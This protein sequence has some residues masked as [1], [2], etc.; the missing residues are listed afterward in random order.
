MDM[1]NIRKILA[2]TI[3]VAAIAVSHAAV[4]DGEVVTRVFGEAPASTGKKVVTRT[5][6]EPSSESAGSTPFALSL[7]PGIGTAQED[8]SVR[9]L[10]L[11][12]LAGRHHS[13]Q[14]VD[15]GLLGNAIVDDVLGVQAACG[16]N[17]VGAS[18]GALQFAFGFNVCEADFCGFQGSWIF[19][20]VGET[21]SGVQI[22]AFNKAEILEG[23]QFGLLNV[24][25]RG[26]G[27]QIGLLNHARALEGVQIG[28]LNFITDSSVPFLPVVNGAF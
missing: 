23:L 5:L 1:A 13:L 6:K 2:A 11:N 27:A 26:V 15:L 25:D 22:S 8:F 14:G 19:N 4:A 7:L 10:R 3:A 21:C 18:E 17:W 12:V 16:W 24:A 9:G 20:S 28:V